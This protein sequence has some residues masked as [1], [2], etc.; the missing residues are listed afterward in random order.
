MLASGGGS[1]INISSTMGRLADRG[2]LAYGTAKAAMIHMSRLAAVDPYMPDRRVLAEAEDTRNPLL[3]RLKFLA[4][5]ASNLDEF[6]MKRI[7]GLKQQVAAGV[8]E[9]TVDGRTPPQQIVECYADVRDFQQRQRLEAEALLTALAPHGISVVGYEELSSEEQ[10]SVREYY[11]GNIFPL[12][13]PLAVRFEQTVLA[14]PK[15]SAV[16]TVR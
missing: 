3:E 5:T 10:A 8:H 13:T 12:V 9:L 1:V 7:G 15:Y 16:S 14:G 4:I 11:Y 6:F 2:Y